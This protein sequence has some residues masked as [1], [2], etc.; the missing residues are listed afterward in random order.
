MGAAYP[1]PFNGSVNFAINSTKSNY[2][3]IAHQDDIY[4]K[5]YLYEILN[6]LKKIF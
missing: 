6:S 2:V 1:N 3:T 4:N 5:D